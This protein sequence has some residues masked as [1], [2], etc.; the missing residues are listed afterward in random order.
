MNTGNGAAGTGQNG[1][2]DKV[3]SVTVVGARGRMG[4]T[5]MREVLHSDNLTL[6]GAVDRSDSPGL[7]QDVGKILNVPDTGVALSDTLAPP[8]NS[9][10]VD[11]S[12]P[13]ATQA[14]IRAALEAGV[15]LVC[16]T[17][18]L[19]RETEDMLRDAALR[20]PVVYAANFSVGVTLLLRL[21][22]ICGDALGTGWDAEIFEIH[23]RLKR[24][25]PSGTALRLGREVAA[26]TGRR[27]QDVFVTDR[28]ERNQ[29]R[30]DAEIGVIAARGGD[31]VGEHTVFFFGEGERLELTHRCTDRAIF[32]RGALRA[33]HWVH[34]KPPGMYDM[35]DVLGL[36]GDESH[37]ID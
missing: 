10:L 25:A 19:D 14:T 9:V 13:I 16:G 36:Y 35:G 15:G 8:R 33:A 34:D 11:F 6:C 20:I 24:D 30:G 23:H 4:T 32:A 31:V 12:L 18:G 5:L 17:T 2:R 7:G 3:V 21:A 26:S 22:A 27:L 29:P 1:E 37:S 28:S